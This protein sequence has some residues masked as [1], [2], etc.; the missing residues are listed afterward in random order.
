[1]SLGVYFLRTRTFT[2]TQGDNPGSWEAS[3]WG[4]GVCLIHNLPAV[5]TAFIAV[6]FKV[7]DHALHLVERSP[8]PF[9]LGQ[10]LSLN[11]FFMTGIF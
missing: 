2:Y 4:A 5:S 10:F 1:M 7:Q 8:V 9:T 11:V 6:F 3:W